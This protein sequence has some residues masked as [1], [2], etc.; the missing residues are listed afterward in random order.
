MFPRPAPGIHSAKKNCERIRTRSIPS[1]LLF[2]YKRFLCHIE[3]LNTGNYVCRMFS[4]LSFYS[5]LLLPHLLLHPEHPSSGGGK[6][7]TS[8]WKRLTILRLSALH[9][10]RRN[11]RKLLPPI[12]PCPSFLASSSSLHSFLPLSIPPWSLGQRHGPAIR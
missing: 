6:K 1:P 7:G 4:L 12:T 5:C 9:S 11:G 3:L 10:L 2:G 8:C